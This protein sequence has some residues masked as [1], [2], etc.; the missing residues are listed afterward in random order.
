[1]G[2]LN[3][4]KIVSDIEEEICEKALYAMHFMTIKVLIKVLKETF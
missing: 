2:K 1:M 4:L 3:V